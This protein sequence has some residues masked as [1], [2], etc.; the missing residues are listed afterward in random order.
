MKLTVIDVMR[1]ADDWVVPNVSVTTMSIDKLPSSTSADEFSIAASG[2]DSSAPVPDSKP[3]E[4]L[5]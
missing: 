4:L 5:S 2:I 3:G 1:N